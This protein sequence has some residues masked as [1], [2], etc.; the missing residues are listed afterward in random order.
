[1][2]K[3]VCERAAEEDLYILL[4]VPGRY[5]TQKMYKKDLE[6]LDCCPDRYKTWEMYEKDVDMTHYILKIVPD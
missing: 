6:M 1:M 4:A 3:D 2:T 5:K